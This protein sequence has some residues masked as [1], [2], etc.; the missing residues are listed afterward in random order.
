VSETETLRTWHLDDHDIP[1]AIAKLER[2]NARAARNG[3][4]G[5]FSW[6][7]GAETSRPVWYGGDAIGKPDYYRT[8]RELIISGDAPKLAGWTFVALL[9]W[10]E[11]VLVTRCT[12]GFE[13]RIDDSLIRVRECDHCHQ[14]RARNDCYLL[15][16]Q[17]GNRVQVGSS[18]VRDF[19]GHDFRP[20]F[21]T[22]GSSLDEMEDGC[23]KTVTVSA[24]AVDVL[25]W[26]ASV[27]SQTGW[28]SRE[29]AETRNRLASGDVLRACLFPSRPRDEELRREY[30]PDESHAAEAA[31]VLAWA[32]AIDPAT[33]S[34]YL[35]NV[36]RAASAEWTGERNVAVLGSAVASYH[37]EISAKAE[38]EAAPVSQF[39][40]EVKQRLELDVTV[41]GETV[42]ETNY[43]VTHLYTLA[44]RD[45]NQMKWFASRG[46]NWETGQE[47][48][49]KATVKEHARYKDVAQTTLT[50]CSEIVTEP[51]IEMEAV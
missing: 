12:P 18:C 23:R 6:A 30:Q 31:K 29:T 38:R 3:L 28:V 34:E 26:A 44:D 19:L 11:E 51:E 41:R 2:I 24:P 37:R 10:D 48:R 49:L 21:I 16:D 9:T 33:P 1:A 39:V 14:D 27:C 22:Y 32:Q 8:E 7:L 5:R 4:G 42:F 40:G 47:L 17:D 36:R 15:E 35:A 43:G 13:G 20:S 50:R 46:Q 45:G 25:T